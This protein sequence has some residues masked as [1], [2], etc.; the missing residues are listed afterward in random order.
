MKKW[1]GIFGVLFVALALTVVSTAAAEDGH[2]K[3]NNTT[4]G[5][6]DSG[7]TDSGTCGNDWAVDTFQRVF[8]VSRQ[9]PDGTYQVRED[10]RH[11]S[12]VTLAGPSAGACET[13]PFGL[14]TAGIEG[15]MGG[16]FLMT[17]TGGTLNPAATCPEI[18]TT[19]T[20]VMAA[21]GATA[22]YTV[23]SFLF[24]YHSHD[25]SLC[26]HSWR[27]ASADFGGNAGDIATT[28]TVSFP[29]GGGG[30]DDDNNDDN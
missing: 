29:G 6:Y 8:T 10:F 3:R 20:F 21:F 1:F 12:F 26:A 5:P 7:S 16:F 4:F 14:I 15:R 11:G 23:D 28:C 25:S 22:T 30:D 2:G 13:N 27:N 18:C 19:A 24:R 17:V 9:S